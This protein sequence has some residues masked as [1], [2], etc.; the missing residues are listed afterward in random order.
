MRS[1]EFGGSKYGVLILQGEQLEVKEG[2]E[3]L[4]LLLGHFLAL[5]SFV[6]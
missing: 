2:E 1:C 5:P 4:Y 3:Y 6:C